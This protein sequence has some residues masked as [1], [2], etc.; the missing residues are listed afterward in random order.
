MSERNLCAFSIM[1][2]YD[3]TYILSVESSILEVAGMTLRACLA[4]SMKIFRKH[5]E[6]IA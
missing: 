4:H 3:Q 5:I 1:C 6:M 2:I